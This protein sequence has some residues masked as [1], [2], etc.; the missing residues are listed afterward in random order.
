MLRI[1]SSESGSAILVMLVLVLMFSAIGIMAIRRSGTDV[2]ISFNQVRRGQAFQLADASLAR[3][4]VELN[5]D[6]TWRDGWAGQSFG[7][8]VYSATISDSSSG[9]M[10]GDTLMVEVSGLIIGD[11]SSLTELE[12]WLVP[13]R[14]SPFQFAVFG[15]DRVRMED[16][17]CT[18][19]WNS[20]SGSYAETQSTTGGAVGSNDEVRLEDFTTI[21]GDAV[22][23]SSGDLDIDGTVTVSGSQITNYPTVDP[24]NVPASEFTWAQSVNAAPAGFSGSGYSYSG[25][26]LSIGASNTLTL[27]GGIYYFD[28]INLSA[29]AKIVIAPGAKVIIYSTGDIDLQN[30]S[31][32]NGGGNAPDLVIYSSGGDLDM[33]GNTEFR[34]AY[35]GANARIELD[36]SA[37]FYGSMMVDRAEVEMAGCIHYDRALLSG[38][39]RGPVLSYRKV[40]WREK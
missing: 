23:T 3:V 15:Y 9:L 30:S 28:N 38:A 29:N 1:R 21:G 13:V 5:S 7:N 33:D 8:G 6:S 27:A 31:S 24:I 34:G 37:D 11:P 10:G 17:A 40:A 22:T 25:N 26:N 32:F 16:N 39:Q 2:D 20:D 14:N 36:A 18:D 35:S 12:A 4:M 19:S